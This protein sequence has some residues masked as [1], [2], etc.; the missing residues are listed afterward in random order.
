MSVLVRRM[1]GDA[2]WAALRGALNWLVMMA[3]TCGF[4]LRN[5]A[6]YAKQRQLQAR[7]PAPLR[8]QRSGE[9]GGGCSSSLGPCAAGCSAALPPLPLARKCRPSGASSSSSVCGRSDVAEEER[10]QQEEEE[11]GAARW[12]WEAGG[13]AAE[14]P[15]PVKPP[16]AQGVLGGA[17]AEPSAA[18]A[19]AI[20]APRS[21]PAAAARGRQGVAQAGEGGGWEVREDGA[22]L[23]AQRVQVQQQVNEQKQQQQKQQQHQRAQTSCLRAKEDA[24]HVEPMPVSPPHAGSGFSEGF[25]DLLVD[26]GDGWHV[27]DLAAWEGCC[28]HGGDDDASVCG[29]RRA[30]GG[31]DDDG[32]Q[33]E[34]ACGVAGRGGRRSGGDGLGGDVAGWR[35]LAGSP[36][37]RLWADATIDPSLLL[38]GDWE[39]ARWWWLD[40][41]CGGVGWHNWSALER[42]RRQ[43]ALTWLRKHAASDAAGLV[44]V[45]PLVPRAGGPPAPPSPLSAASSG[46]LDVA[47]DG[48]HSPTQCRTPRSRSGSPAARHGPPQPCAGPGP[49]AD[50]RAM[51]PNGQRARAPPPTTPPTPRAGAQVVRAALA[52]Q[53]QAAYH[54][55]CEGGAA[56]AT[57]RKTPPIYLA[58]HRSCS[59][60]Q[61]PPAS[62]CVCPHW[63]GTQEPCMLC[64]SQV[65]VSILG[66]DIEHV[67]AQLAQQLAAQVEAS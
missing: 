38:L 64:R 2:R 1:R 34:V 52:A 61:S 15:T 12:A 35:R 51:P 29:R 44:H 54:R 6:S 41:R 17:P 5:R 59:Q 63:L 53:R 43:P 11:E 8:R 42:H 7:A 23:D 32:E 45:P 62:G 37:A 56:T 30:R 40:W 65:T 39:G 14:L 48:R 18:A 28:C 3:L 4:E 33:Q 26:L 46:R 55:H 49:A 16:R 19:A 67:P 24:R 47:W 60:S 31:D 20:G 27:P 10:W 36:G 25:D 66:V 57:V 13:F 50:E 22:P 21:A 58:T 9:G